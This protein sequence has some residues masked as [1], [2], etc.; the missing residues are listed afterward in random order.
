MEES[1]SVARSPKF[2]AVKKIEAVFEI[3]GGGE[4]LVAC[5]EASVRN[6]VL[7]GV[8]KPGCSKPGCLLI[9]TRKRSFALFCALLRSFADL[10]LLGERQSIA[11][12]GVHATDP[13][14]SQQ[15][16]G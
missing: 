3:G 6:F 13:R 9:F 1:F 14:N 12:R 15:E 5:F 4:T 7:L 11:Q 2:L 16:N 10:P 8:P